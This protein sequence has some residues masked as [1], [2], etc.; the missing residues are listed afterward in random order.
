MQHRKLAGLAVALLLYLVAYPLVFASSPYYLG[1]LTTASTLALISAGVWLTF[2][3]GR[4]NIGQGAF[5][6][7]GGYAAAILITGPLE[8]SFEL[9]IPFWLAIPFGLDDIRF[10]IVIPKLSF[11]L[12]LPLAGLVS[13]LIGVLIGLPILRLRGVYFA[14]ISLSLTETA[15]LSAQSFT[16]LTGGAKGIT[17]IPLPGALE[18]FGIVLIPDFR[19]IDTHL[20]L[21][22]LAA[23]LLIFGFAVL[24]RLV[25]SRIGWI[26]RSLQQ[27]E[28]LASSIGVNISALRVLAFSIS[29]FLAGIGGAFFIASQQSIYPSTFQ[30]PDSVYFMLY[31]FLGGLGYVF[32]PIAGTLVLFISFELLQGLN[33]YQ[34]LI[35]ALIMIVLM[36][37]LPNGLLSLNVSQLLSRSK[38]LSRKTHLVKGIYQRW[39]S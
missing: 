35:Y 33:E 3:I 25:N 2:Y 36:L 26:F 9:A 11:W 13:A 20:A 12:A 27:N 21:Y 37:W 29:C 32:G 18:I 16:S 17:N 4:I 34:P 19:D 24:Y 22:Y 10:A 1:I 31:C 7:V 23:G 28:E 14:M 30:I 15:R 38:Y 39:R 8:L 5:A 6:L